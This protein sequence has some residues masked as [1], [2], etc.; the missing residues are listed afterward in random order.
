MKCTLKHFIIPFF[1][2]FHKVIY[3]TARSFIS[4]F[5]PLIFILRVIEWPVKKSYTI[6]HFKNPVLNTRYK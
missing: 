1:D 4:G 2:H 5:V 3:G 6:F